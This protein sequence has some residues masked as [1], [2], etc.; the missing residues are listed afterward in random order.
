MSKAKFDRTRL[1][2]IK[3]MRRAVPVIFLGALFFAV[4]RPAFASDDW[5]QKIS[6]EFHKVLGQTRRSLGPIHVKFLPVVRAKKLVFPKLPEEI[7]RKLSTNGQTR[8][9]ALG[10]VYPGSLA[11]AMSQIGSAYQAAIDVEQSQDYQNL[12]TQTLEPLNTH[13]DALVKTHDQLTNQAPDLDSENDALSSEKQELD[14]EANDLENRKSALQSAIDSYNESCGGKT[15]PPGP[16]EQCESERQNLK[17]QISQLNNDIS[18][19]SDK[20]NDFNS[21]ADNLRT[22]ASSWINTLK[23][24]INDMDQWGEDVKAAFAQA[25]TGDCTEDERDHLQAI[26][27]NACEYPPLAR[28]TPDLGCDVL[29]DYTDRFQGCY[30]ARKAIID[31]C[32]KG[33]PDDRHQVELQSVLN[34][35]NR[36]KDFLNQQCGGVGVS[37]IR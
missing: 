35:L 5:G 15:L 32:Y 12:P 9:G 27:K 34:G 2:V 18:A 20:A 13:W 14:S 30:D 37:T 3:M 4:P 7:L 33:I 23:S 16:Y 26:V 29:E 10:Y 19:F 17:S 36:C 1:R 22:S 28:C 25:D 8:L 6:D 31:Q 11:E 24:W 21:R